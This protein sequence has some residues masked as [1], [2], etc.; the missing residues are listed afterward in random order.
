G[1]RALGSE[2][3][4]VTPR[5]HLPIYAAGRMLF[6]RMLRYRDFSSRDTIVG[7]D[8]DGYSIAG[9]GSSRH[10]ANIKGVIADVLPY[11]RGASLASMA[12]QADLEKLHARRADLVIAPSRYC[13]SRLD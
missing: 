10:V 7:F 9:R 1:I 12:F 5:V 2:V 8:T 13:A 6:N 11:E 3:N 4:F